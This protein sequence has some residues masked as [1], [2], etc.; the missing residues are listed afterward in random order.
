MSRRY[1][2]E[3]DRQSS[4]WQ[5]YRLSIGANPR[6]YW[7]TSFPIRG[8]AVEEKRQIMNDLPF[9]TK[10]DEPENMGGRRSTPLQ[11]GTRSQNALFRGC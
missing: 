9:G 7:P 4:D 1:L 5:S 10:P 8:G 3:G 2:G 11:T 6:G